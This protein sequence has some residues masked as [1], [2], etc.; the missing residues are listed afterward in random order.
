MGRCWRWEGG[1][2]KSLVKTSIT[3]ISLLFH[4]QDSYRWIKHIKTTAGILQVSTDNKTID[5]SADIGFF[6]RKMLWP[7]SE[8]I[9]VFLNSRAG[10]EKFS[11]PPLKKNL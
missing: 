1:S 2:V 5:T 4:L 6:A 8:K 9:C 10:R 3:D 7:P 11:G